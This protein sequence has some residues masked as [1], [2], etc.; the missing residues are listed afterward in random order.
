MSRLYFA[1]Q[2]PYWWNRDGGV[3]G[4]EAKELE[5]VRVLAE[6]TEGWLSDQQGLALF[7]LARRP[8]PDPVLE[9]GS[10]CGKSTIFQALGCKMSGSLLHAV[11]PHKS[12]FEGGKEQYAQDLT[13]RVEGSLSAFQSTIGLSG[14]GPWI[15]T[16][17]TTSANAWN[18]LKDQRFKLV[19]IDGSHDYDDIKF[20][21]STW[22]SSV[23]TGGYLVFHD[24]NFDSVG[25]V[26]S[27]YIDGALFHLEGVVGNGRSAMTLWRRKGEMDAVQVPNSGARLPQSEP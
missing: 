27:S 11:D 4:A 25:R 18:E 17:V 16:H 13:P 5:A 8:L 6:R 3:E 10:F 22:M 20:D 14:L 7:Q 26:I 21:C 1:E 9:I 24:S 23:R 19:F 12:I 15:V 2:L